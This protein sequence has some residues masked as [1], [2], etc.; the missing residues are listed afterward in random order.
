MLTAFCLGVLLVRWQNRIG[1]PEN[2]LLSLAGIAIVFM[3]YSGL[4]CLFIQ[5]AKAV[6]WLRTIILANTF[7]CF[8]SLGLVI[9]YFPLLTNLA[10]LY[11]MLELIV[12]AM[13]V[14]IEWGV[15]RRLRGQ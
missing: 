9:Y 13:V 2:V 11:F 6:P 12:V 15:F 1:M 4:C 10:L 8:L 3:V 7:Y 14:Y 5:P